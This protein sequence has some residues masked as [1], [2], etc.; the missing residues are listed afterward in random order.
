MTRQI[1]SRWQTSDGQNGSVSLV[2]DM[3]EI[4]R[5]SF[6]DDGKFEPKG[7]VSFSRDDID[8]LIDGL[9]RGRGQKEQ[10]EVAPRQATPTPTPAGVVDAQSFA[11]AVHRDLEAEPAAST[12]ERATQTHDRAAPSLFSF[13]AAGLIQPGCELEVAD[14]K[15]ER[16]TGTLAADGSMI[17][18][19]KTFRSP[20]SVWRFFCR[21]KA[22]N[23]AEPDP[24]TL[25]RYRHQGTQRLRILK[26][27]EDQNRADA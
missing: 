14:R 11:D 27:L 6:D 9:E 25:I 15:G 19:G 12:R 18:G 17:F 7:R 21:N 23:T 13:I 3:I 24:L 4:S 1:L 2:G 10:V 5:F 8:R 16:V 26:D 20:T 22:I